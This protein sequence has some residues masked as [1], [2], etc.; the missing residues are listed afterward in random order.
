MAAA[1]TFEE[2]RSEITFV[3][4]VTYTQTYS[5][6]P[7]IYIYMQ[8]IHKKGF[9]HGYSICVLHSVRGL[10]INCRHHR[11]HELSSLIKSGPMLFII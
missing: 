10:P 2:I 11:C 4:F 1:A 7:Y 3:V 6:S 8:F 9:I 5:K